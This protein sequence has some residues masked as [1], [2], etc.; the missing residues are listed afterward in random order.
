MG[1]WD[2][3]S[4]WVDGWVSGW[5]SGLVGDQVL[6]PYSTEN[7]VGIGYPTLGNRKQTT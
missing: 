3:V 2:W 7:R 1:G 5:V 6:S 4:G